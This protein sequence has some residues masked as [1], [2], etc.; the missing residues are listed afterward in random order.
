MN[1][2]RTVVA[3]L[4]ATSIGCSGGGGG[5]GSDAGG[6]ETATACDGS[7][8][9]QVLSA[10]DVRQI[11]S[12]GVTEAGRSGVLGTFA[13]LD[14]VGNVL[15]VYQMP[16][17]NPSTTI[18][19]QIGARGGLEGLVVPAA[20]AAISKAGTGAFLS[21]QG[22]AFS[23]RTAS[24][25]VQENFNPG[26]NNQPGGPLFGVQFSQ[27]LCSDVMVLAGQGGRFS[28][29]SGLTG[30]VGPHPLPLGLAA[31]VGGLPLYKNGDVV[32]GIGVELDGTYSLD[33]NISD[34]DSSVE[35]LIALSATR[36]FEASSLRTAARVSV[37]K[38]LRYTDVDYSDLEPLA[39]L[40]PL[41]EDSFIAVPPFFAGSVRGGAL[42]GDASSGFARTSFHGIPAAVLVDNGGNERFHPQA[43]RAAGAASLTQ[44][45]VDALL[46]SALSTASRAR[47]AIRRPLDS[48]ARVSIWVVDVDGSPLGFIRSEDAPVFGTDVSLQK[49]RTAVFFSRTDAKARL[50]SA[51]F[52]GYT[53]AAQILVGQDV[54]QNGTAFTSRAIG[55]L[56]RPFFPDGIN[57]NNNGPLSLPFPNKG[58][59]KTWSPFNVG[60]QLDIAFNNLGASLGLFGPIS[61]IPSSCGDTAAFGKSLANGIQIFPGSTPLYRGTTLIGAVGVSGDGI[62][63]DDLIS[64]YGSGR[65]GLDDVGH[66]ALGDQKYGFHPDPSLRSDN[67]ALSIRSTRLRFVSCPEGPFVGSDDQNVC[68]E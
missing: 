67:N 62:D 43:G 5:G 23:T 60:L 38:F 41:S 26:E 29:G 45:E 57:G 54:F 27:L 3:L 8:A 20:A 36:G 66:S 64:F 16:G 39:E 6:S 63:Q 19:G 17:A 34:S 7:C 13:V 31:D 11:I 42:F 55:N 47:A 52:G 28:H 48:S 14:R 40:S 65:R 2:F 33:R 24:Q 4:L 46:H 35:D 53:A 15:A 68:E 22:N 1:C 21:S 37:G 58:G 30:D 44:N 10:D 12:Q 59:E 50:D 25:I 51:G 49:A 18:N 61:N 56:A 32:G 9:S